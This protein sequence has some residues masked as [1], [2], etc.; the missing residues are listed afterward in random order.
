M[1]AL[2]RLSVIGPP[3]SLIRPPTVD[4]DACSV[5]IEATYLKETKNSI[6]V[7]VLS[8]HINLVTV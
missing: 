4:I 8:S 3:P 1:V 2:T 6:Q 7:D 5:D